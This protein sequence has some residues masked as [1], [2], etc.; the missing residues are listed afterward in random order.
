MS[1]EFP[2][3]PHPGNVLIA[4]CQNVVFHKFKL[5]HICTRREHLMK[6]GFVV[7]A[8][9]FVLVACPLYSSAGGNP[10]KGVTCAGHG[11]CVVKGG[12]PMC[13]C[14]EGFAPDAVTGL[15]CQAT[16]ASVPAPTPAP[17]PAASSSLQPPPPS[18]QQ[19][20]PS[21]VSQPLAAPTSPPPANAI[22][23]QFQAAGKG[24]YL[25]Q[26][27]TPDNQIQQ[28]SAPCTFYQG[29]GRSK[30]EISGDMEFSQDLVV[31]EST[32]VT[33]HSEKKVLKIVG[34]SMAIAGVVPMVLGAADWAGGASVDIIPA[35]GWFTIGGGTLFIGGMVLGL[36]AGGNKLIVK[37]TPAAYPAPAPVA[38][39]V[40]APPPAATPVDTPPPAAAPASLIGPPPAPTSSVQQNDR[41]LK[42]VSIGLLPLP[43]GGL[44]GV[45]ATF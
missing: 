39:P 45:S 34:L 5:T 6:L 11:T 16:G 4:R 43:E 28:C 21:P 14:H 18:E 10:C 15:S 17:A 12:D 37:N 30:V 35:E 32:T 20:L 38:A 22:P 44:L 19:P 27:I 8:M 29:P 40:P 25:V 24:T 41:S 9:L 13:A 31:A 2:E 33:I 42:L 26:L 1:N 3:S 23:V 7:V 36:M